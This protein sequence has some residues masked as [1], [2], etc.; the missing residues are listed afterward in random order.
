MEWA[1]VLISALVGGEDRTG[2]GQLVAV[3]VGPIP[4][5]GRLIA[6]LAVV[7]DAGAALLPALAGAAASAASLRAALLFSAA[8]PASAALF[9][10]CLHRRA[11]TA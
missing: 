8:V 2:N 9:L 10:F 7:Q 3:K 5:R 4:P 6:S 1:G 11:R